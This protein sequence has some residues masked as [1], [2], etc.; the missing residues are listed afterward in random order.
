MGLAKK[1]IARLDIKDTNL[2]NVIRVLG[3]RL[4]GVSIE[5]AEK[6]FLNGR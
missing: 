4:I 2:I 6:Y 3:H 5:F 1:M